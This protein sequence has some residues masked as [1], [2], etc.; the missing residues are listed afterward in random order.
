MIY[1]F[2]ELAFQ[3]LTVD[4]FYHHKGTYSVKARPYAAL[5]FRVSGT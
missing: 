2:D 3:V 4:R 5:S 1:N